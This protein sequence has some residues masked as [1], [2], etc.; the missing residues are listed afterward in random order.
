MTRTTISRPYVSPYVPNHQSY[1]RS[2]S[3]S[4]IGV[5]ASFF[6]FGLTRGKSTIWTQDGHTYMINKTTNQP[7]RPKS[8]HTPT[9]I[10][11]WIF[12]L[13]YP[14]SM[15][16]NTPLLFTYNTRVYNSVQY[17]TSQSESSTDPS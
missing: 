3:E 11:W 4:Q 6:I 15:A 13:T 7:I 10:G 12:I 9:M 17:Y 14:R 5:I 16:I 2:L 8:T 1:A